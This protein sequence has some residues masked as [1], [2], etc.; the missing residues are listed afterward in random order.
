MAVTSPEESIA[1][2]MI[3]MHGGVW[4]EQSEKSKETMLD[5]AKLILASIEEYVVG[6]EKAAWELGHTHCFHVEDPRNTRP[7][8]PF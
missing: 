6:R 3:Q 7:Y 5:D 1:R 8:N 4:E 2:T